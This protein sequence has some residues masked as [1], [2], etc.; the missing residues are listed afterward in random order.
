MTNRIKYTTLFSLLSLS[1]LSDLAGAQ[2]ISDAQRSLQQLNHKIA[3]LQKDLNQTHTQQTQL[4][5]EL[6]TTEQQIKHN[7]V[8]LQ[9]LQQ[10]I[11]LKKSEIEKIEKKIAESQIKFNQLQ[12]LLLHQIQT[13]Y[14]QQPNQPL[15]WFIV[16]P[17]KAEI[18]KILSYYH[19]ILHTYKQTLEE[20][21]L[22]QAQLQI[23]QSQLQQEV[24]KL[25]HLQVQAQLIQ[26]QLQAHK[27]HHQTLLVT[28]KNRVLNQENTLNQYQRNR[29]NLS[30]IL[31]KL[32]RE[33]V[34]QTRHSMTTMKRKLPNPV[35]V[36]PNHIHKIHQGIMLYTTEGSPVQA[37]YPG[38]VVFGEWL[39]GYGL[40]IIIDHGWGLMTLYANNHTLTKHVGDI[41]NQGEQ[42]ALVG[43]GGISKQ[44]GL[45]FEVRKHG[46]AISPLE[47]LRTNH[48]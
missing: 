36:E 45:Y 40:L 4:Q 13:R 42:I 6:S 35:N 25:H 16:H 3:V 12:A 2:T 10:Q 20:M 32:S 31:N 15:A 7:E 41:V 17:Q 29:D 38:K 43:H 30:Q 18:E 26:Q 14:K 27:N 5:R 39:N 8:T 28:V 9:T 37:V 22:T 48:R 24:E 1:A 33:S 47:W 34:I 46:K 23:Q 11:P 21:K 19:Y 44:T